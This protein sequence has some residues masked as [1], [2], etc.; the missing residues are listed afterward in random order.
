MILYILY[1]KICI[2]CGGVLNT[3]IG[4]I[5]SPNYPLS[6]SE[7]LECFYKIVVT[8]GS[9]IKLTILDLELSTDTYSGLPC[10]EDFIEVCNELYYIKYIF[11]FSYYLS[12]PKLTKNNELL[13]FFSLADLICALFIL[14]TLVF[15][16]FLKCT[17][18]FAIFSEIFIFLMDF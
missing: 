15:V 13:F 16:I 18:I 5:I 1:L 4:H 12:H 6:V 2:G 8:K 3:G 10:K 14:K 11:T 9:Q 7:T 17:L